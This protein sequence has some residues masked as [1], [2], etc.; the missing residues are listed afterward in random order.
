V[1]DV[2]RGQAIAARDLRLAGLATTEQPALMDQVRSSCAMDGAID[3]T[4]AEQ[5]GIGGIDDGINVKPGDVTLQDL[6]AI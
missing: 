4:T 5:G 2:L 3:A 6:D 1:D